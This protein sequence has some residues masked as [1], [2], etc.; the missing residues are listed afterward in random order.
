MVLGALPRRISENLAVGAA[1]DYFFDSRILAVATTLPSPWNGADPDGAAAWPPS[2]LMT[3]E[4]CCSTQRAAVR[5]TAGSPRSSW[6][7]RNCAP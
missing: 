7:L 3:A 4:A 6:V 5:W 2:W 1:A